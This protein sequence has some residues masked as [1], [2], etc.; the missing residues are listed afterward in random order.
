MKSYAIQ[1]KLF[2]NRQV[3]DTRSQSRLGSGSPR[4]VHFCRDRQAQ[5]FEKGQVSGSIFWEGLKKLG[6]LCS[7]PAGKSFRTT[8]RPYIPH[9]KWLDIIQECYELYFAKSFEWIRQT[10]LYQIYVYL[11]SQ[12]KLFW[13]RKRA[14]QLIKVIDLNCFNL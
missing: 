8:R 4:P 12:Y 6:L 11:I 5:N 2:V 10:V 9:K 13:Y 1:W 3:K 14:Q 7:K